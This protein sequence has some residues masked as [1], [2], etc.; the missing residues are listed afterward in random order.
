MIYFDQVTGAAF[1]RAILEQALSQDP[2]IEIV[3]MASDPFE[4]SEMIL[5]LKPDVVT[6]DIEIPKMNGGFLFE[7]VNPSISFTGD[8]GKVYH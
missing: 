7:K 6:L 8:Y 5:S 3:G 2:E 1:V 4:A